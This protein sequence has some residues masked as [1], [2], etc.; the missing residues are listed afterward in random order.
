[1][2]TVH[3]PADQVFALAALLADN[4]AEPVTVRALDYVFRASNPLSERL[5]ARL[6]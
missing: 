5:F 1:M 4:G 6:G 2:L 3:C